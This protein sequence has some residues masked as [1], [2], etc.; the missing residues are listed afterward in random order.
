MVEAV[1]DGRLAS[2]VSN[3]SQ[4]TGC[5]DVG[6]CILFSPR[7]THAHQQIHRSLADDYSTDL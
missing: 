7:F 4:A 5:V 6:G 2:D 3:Q 1:R